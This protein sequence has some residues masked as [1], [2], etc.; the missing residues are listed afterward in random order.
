VTNRVD[1][2][3]ILQ[4]FSTQ[5]RRATDSDD[6]ILV[7]V[8]DH[9]IEPP[10]M[11]DDHLPAS[12]SEFA[13]RI[14]EQ[15]DG[16]IVWRFQDDEVATLALN[17]VVGRAPEELG[18]EPTSFD[19][20]R[21]GC[22]DVDER[23][24]DMN[25]AGVLASMC[26]PSFPG[27]AGKLFISAPDKEMST[28]MLRAYNDWAIDEWSG[29][30]PGRFIPLAIGPLWDAELLAA[31]VHRIA[32]KGCHAITFSEDPSKLGLPSIHSSA[33][34]PFWSACCDEGTVPCIHLGSSSGMTMTSVDAPVD[35]VTTLA[36]FSVMKCA[37]DLAWSPIFRKFPDLRAALSEG[38]IGWIPYLLDRVD[39]V[40][41]RHH[42]WTGQDF[43]SS[44]PSDVFREHVIVCFIE[45]PVGLANRDAIGI[46]QITWECDYPHGDSVW[47]DCPEH[48]MAQATGMTDEE[49]NLVTHR[50]A[51][52]FFQFDPF[53]GRPRSDCTV[54]ALRAEATDVSTANHRTGVRRGKPGQT[55]A[56]VLG[57]VKA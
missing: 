2:R 34:D 32:A 49:I 42:Y 1:G 51:M 44:R 21:P 48:F 54:A 10:G 15:S 7:S 5:W 55:M 30:H 19:E 18:Y 27:F 16:T 20:L 46:D 9:V 37:A 33:W 36:P 53:T 11:F 13:P 52:R 29:S 28:V 17:A 24:R 22:F 6:L 25:A 14:V 4:G 56:D 39:R 40:Y 57:N 38:G 47:P 43:G 3:T 12:W 26:F 50:N 41:D 35:V 45:D 23:V 31:E 8:D